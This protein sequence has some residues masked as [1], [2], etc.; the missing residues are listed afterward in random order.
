MRVKSVETQSTV[1]GVE[2]KLEQRRLPY[3]YPYRQIYPS[4][5][6]IRLRSSPGE[7]ISSHP[8]KSRFQM[9]VRLARRPVCGPSGDGKNNNNKKNSFFG[10]LCFHRVGVAF[11]LMCVKC[12][13]ED[14]QDSV[15]DAGGLKRF[16]NA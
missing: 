6:T 7:V 14:I 9:R 1:V 2:W 16:W 13:R 4:H 8:L 15:Q 3:T 11:R 12:R 5:Q 10:A